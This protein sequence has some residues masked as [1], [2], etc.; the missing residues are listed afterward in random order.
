[1]NRE[2]EP[3]REGGGPATEEKRRKRKIRKRE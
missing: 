2:K 3:K 1:M